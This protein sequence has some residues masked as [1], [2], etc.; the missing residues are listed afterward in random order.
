MHDSREFEHVVHGDE[1][2]VI[3]DK[4]YWSQARSEWCGKQGVANGILRKPSRGQKLRPATVRVNR[5]LSRMRCG[6]E[7]IFG[8]WKRS[9]GYRRVRYVGRE[10]NRL[11]LEFKCIS[12]FA[13]VF[14]LPSCKRPNCFLNR[15]SQFNSGREYHSFSQALYRLGFLPRRIVGK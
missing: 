10:P 1:E 14:C 7:R 4:A 8:W 12:M 5:R 2:M 11:E 13:I 9:A 15:G 3:A 6:I